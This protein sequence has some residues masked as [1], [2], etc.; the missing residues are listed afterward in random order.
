MLVHVFGQHFIESTSVALFKDPKTVIHIVKI[1]RSI[2]MNMHI[3]KIETYDV[4]KYLYTA[5]FTKNW[6]TQ[7]IYVFCK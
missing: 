7:F 4:E 1:Y 6:K 5:S 2:S 3:T